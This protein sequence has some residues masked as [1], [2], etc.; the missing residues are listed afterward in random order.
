MDPTLDYVSRYL[1]EEEIDELN[2]SAFKDQADLQDIEKP[3]YEILG[4][5]YPPTPNEQSAS[6]SQSESDLSSSSSS[7]SKSSISINDT[8]VESITVM[9]FHRGIEEGMKFLPIMNKLST[10]IK[11]NIVSVDSAEVKYKN[12]AEL[13]LVEKVDLGMMP[14]SKKNSI[15]S[16]LDI[17][18]GPNR[19]ISVID[20]EEPITDDVYDKVLLD[21][22]DGHLKE[23]IQSLRETLQLEAISGVLKE[24]QGDHHELHTLLI[25]CAE[26]VAIYDRRIA[27]ELLTKIRLKS[28]PNGNAIQRLSSVLADA[29]EARLAGVGSDYYR[30]LIAK[31][32]RTPDIYFLKAYHLYL[33]AA[34]FARVFYCFSNRNILVAARNARKVHV[35]DL[36]IKFGF[37]WPSLIQDFS[38]R[39]GGPP[40]LRITG[41]E[42]PEPGFRPAKRVESIGQR[43]EEYARSFN[44]P[45][46][47][48]VIASQW[49]SIR[50]EELAINDDEVLIVN[51]MIRLKNVKDETFEIDC[52]RN[53]VL[54]LIRQIKPQIFI[55]AHSNRSYSS[56][57]PTRFRQVLSTYAVFYDLLDRTIPHGDKQRLLPENVYFV[58]DI[59]NIVACEGSDWIEKPETLKQWQRR[60][61]Q[62]GFEQ[63]PVNLNIVKEC[64]NLVRDGYDNR[65][66]V[67]E[68]DGWLLQGWKGRSLTTNQFRGRNITL[69]KKL[70]YANIKSRQTYTHDF[71]HLAPAR[72]QLLQNLRIKKIQK[73][74]K[75]N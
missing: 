71:T 13:K 49:E 56:F 47:Y 54:K 19:K 37:Q 60:N 48:K 14:R 17:F 65:Y 34:P 20:S 8:L 63:L 29:L 21:H 58:T 11:E 9:E 3:F 33:R 57:F 61:I 68:D 5:K 52:P 1:L 70:R 10:D 32:F 2:I 4:Q 18:E 7:T 24:I 59:I 25:H 53:R 62:A 39:E 23:E 50:I 51:C 46:I 72:Q 66:F 26:A 12:S 27:Q 64:K 35:I 45:F 69:I 55:Q 38:K 40:K 36:G 30:G 42:F 6:S 15:C 28:S 16:E 67:Q 73:K 22:G 41:I 43:L 44:V 31:R 75:K 74:N